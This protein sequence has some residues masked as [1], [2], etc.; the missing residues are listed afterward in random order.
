MILGD[1]VLEKGYYKAFGRR[2]ENKKIIISLYQSQFFKGEIEA[3]ETNDDFEEKDID[4]AKLIPYN[5][6]FMKMIFGSLDFNAYVFI[7]Y[8]N[9]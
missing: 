9:R 1:K 7:P 4:F 2:D 3:I 6:S 5:Q 8:M